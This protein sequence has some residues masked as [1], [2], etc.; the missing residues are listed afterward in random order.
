MKAAEE[1]Y[2]Y[3]FTPLWFQR[4]KSALASQKIPCKCYTENI[5]CT[6]QFR[7]F[8]VINTYELCQG[9][10]YSSNMIM[11]INSPAISSTVVW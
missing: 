11:L 9:I 4:Q 8:S 3:R 1:R 7:K 10:E 5:L 6:Y 2:S